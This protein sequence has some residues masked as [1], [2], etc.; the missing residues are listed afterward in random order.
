MKFINGKF[1]FLIFI[2]ILFGFFVSIYSWDG[3]VYFFDRA[4]SR[5]PADN[6]NTFS[7]KNLKSRIKGHSNQK[8]I[9]EQ[10]IISRSDEFITLNLKNFFVDKQKTTVCSAYEQVQL[11]FAALN[12]AVSGE[13]PMITVTAPCSE[14]PSNVSY[15]ATITVP[16]SEI[17]SRPVKDK[18]PLTFEQQKYTFS[19]ISDEWP[20]EFRLK[21]VTFINEDKDLKL[22]VEVFRAKPAID[23]NL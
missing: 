7:L 19:N 5:I 15:I 22:N 20:L 3:V 12:V 23:F 21:S 9:L 2:P 17:K 6:T 4:N 10:T 14:D 1:S 8:I 16:L 18:T 11:S 13:P